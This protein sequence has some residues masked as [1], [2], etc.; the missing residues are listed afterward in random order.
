M[1]QGICRP[2]GPAQTHRATVG[3]ER[4]FQTL[5]DVS[6]YEAGHRAYPAAIGAEVGT[7]MWMGWADHRDEVEAFAAM[8]DCGAWAVSHPASIGLHLP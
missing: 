2:P 6:R 3:R 4:A 5:G 8:G 7:P 1:L